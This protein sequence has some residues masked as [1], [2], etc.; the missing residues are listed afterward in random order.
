MKL[1]IFLVCKG[2]EYAL[3]ISSSNRHDINLILDG[4]AFK[5]VSL[6]CKTEHTSNDE[7]KLH[8]IGDSADLLALLFELTCVTKT[9]TLK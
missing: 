1:T 2:E 5:Y 3:I 9:L 4:Y 8:V 7:Y 6:S